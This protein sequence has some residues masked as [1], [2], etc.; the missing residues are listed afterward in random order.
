M[1]CLMLPFVWHGQVQKSVGGVD[2]MRV[3]ETNL[4]GCAISPRVFADSK[5]VSKPFQNLF[6]QPE[7][8]LADS[9]P[10]TNPPSHVRVALDDG[11]CRC[12]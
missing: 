12:E 5:H 1:I 6:R 2:D 8:N 11:E 9:S 7:R 4:C 3:D 10:T